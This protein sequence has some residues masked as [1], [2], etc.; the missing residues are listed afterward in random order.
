MLSIFVGIVPRA[1]AVRIWD[2]YLLLGGSAILRVATALAPTPT[3]ILTLNLTLNLNLIG[4]SALPRVATALVL[5]SQ[6]GLT[7]CVDEQAVIDTIVRTA[8]LW[9]EPGVL[10]A[11]AFWE[12]T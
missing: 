7:T 4:G 2:C 11:A 1:T 3:L 8:R 9:P 5:A 10:L 12:V 6:V